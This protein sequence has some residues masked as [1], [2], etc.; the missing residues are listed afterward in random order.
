L[1]AYSSLTLDGRSNVESLRRSERLGRR[2]LNDGSG[3]DGMLAGVGV[4]GLMMI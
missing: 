4:R 1:S 3:A 2:D